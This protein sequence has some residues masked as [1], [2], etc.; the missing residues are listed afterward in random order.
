M[1][2]LKI[3]LSFVTVV[4]IACSAVNDQTPVNASGLWNVQVRKSTGAI[5]QAILT[6][7]QS[8]SDSRFSG[9]WRFTSV[10]T[11]NAQVSGDTKTGVFKIN[12][13]GGSS[14]IDVAGTF[15]Q[16][17]YLGTYK[18]YYSDNTTAAGNITMTKALPTSKLTFN[19]QPAENFFATVNISDGK[20]QVYGGFAANKTV[21]E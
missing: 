21:L 1:F 11:S 10:Q 16:S 15:T 12:E 14:Y 20:T 7:S 2:Q 17:A 3:L 9:S 19:I 8:G 4:L 13:I 5:N 18:A 6:I